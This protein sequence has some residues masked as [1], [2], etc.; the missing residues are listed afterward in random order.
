[1]IV[2]ISWCRNELFQYGDLSAVASA[3][4]LLAAVVWSCLSVYPSESVAWDLYVVDE[5]TVVGGS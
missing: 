3:G 5:R 1:M 2:C 4:T